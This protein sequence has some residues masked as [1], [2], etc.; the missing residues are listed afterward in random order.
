MCHKLLIQK[1]DRSY[2]IVLYNLFLD[3][4]NLFN[5]TLLIQNRGYG[6][7]VVTMGANTVIRIAIISTL[8]V[9]ALVILAFCVIL[10]SYRGYLVSSIIM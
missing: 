7:F 10:P 9:A 2:S 6:G 8:I 4:P 5:P 1:R 3:Y